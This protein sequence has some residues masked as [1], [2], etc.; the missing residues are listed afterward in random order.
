MADT[1]A[2][3]PPS[4][5]DNKVPT[6]IGV[7]IFCLGVAS[8]VVVLRTYTRG[9]ITNQMGVDDYFAIASLLMIYGTGITMLFSPSVTRSG[10]RGVAADISQ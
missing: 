6:T 1:T 10:P 9:W 4:S 2:P 3:L 5:Y 8:A 7:T